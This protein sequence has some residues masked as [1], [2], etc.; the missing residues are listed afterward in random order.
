[1]TDFLVTTTDSHLDSK[2]GLGLENMLPAT[3]GRSGVVKGERAS[4]V[5]VLVGEAG[6]GE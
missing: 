5:E 6:Q 3:T 2:Q 4:P 1:M